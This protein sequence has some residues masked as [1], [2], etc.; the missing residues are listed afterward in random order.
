[1]NLNQ[2]QQQAKRRT[3][4]PRSLTTA[5]CARFAVRLKFSNANTRPYS[6][7][8]PSRASQGL[9]R[10]LFRPLQQQQQQQYKGHVCNITC[11]TAG[12]RPLSERGSARGDTVYKTTTHVNNCC[13]CCKCIQVPVF[14]MASY[15]YRLYLG[16]RCNCLNI[17]L[18]QVRGQH[19]CHSL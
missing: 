3:N 1:M 2:L 11:R 6:A 13:G 7:G 12:I 8:R 15:G 4:Q 17:R 10:K 9:L 5:S 18:A 14:C 16:M 19:S